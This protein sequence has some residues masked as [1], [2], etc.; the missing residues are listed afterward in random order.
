MHNHYLCNIRSILKDICCRILYGTQTGTAKEWAQKLREDAEA[1]NYF[2][3]DVQDLS[4]YDLD[5][6]SSEDLVLF[7]VSTYTDGTPPG[8]K[9]FFAEYSCR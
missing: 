4:T 2:V 3:E 8:I 7:V 1:R 9:S 5:D 6:L